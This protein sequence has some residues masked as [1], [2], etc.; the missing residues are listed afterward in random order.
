MVG[1]VDVA[2]AGHEYYNSAPAHS[3]QLRRQVVTAHY[4]GSQNR[5]TGRK[6]K[7]GHTCNTKDKIHL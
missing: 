5:D 3:P 7:E 6:N 1:D 4:H 2:C